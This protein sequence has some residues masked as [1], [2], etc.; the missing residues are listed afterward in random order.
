ME[1]GKE[2]RAGPWRAKRGARQGP[3]QRVGDR[4]LGSGGQGGEQ[5]RAEEVR[6][7]GGPGPGVCSGELGQAFKGEEGSWAQAL[8]SEEGR[9]TQCLE[10]EQ[11]TMAQALED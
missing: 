7:V 9:R 2:S 11:R 6:R 8:E 5:G 3:G 4:G 1:G 10:G